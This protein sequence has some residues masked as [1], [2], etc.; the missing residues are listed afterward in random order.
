MKLNKTYLAVILALFSYSALAGNAVVSQSTQATK[1]AINSVNIGKKGKTQAGTI[2][3]ELTKDGM[4]KTQIATETLAD[5]HE[6]AKQL[7]QVKKDYTVG[8]GLSQ[9]MSCKAVVETKKITTSERM[10]KAVA[11]AKQDEIISS[12]KAQTPA[13]K[14][15]ERH[16]THKS[17]YCG[18]AE[19]KNGECLQSPILKPLMDTD[20]TNLVGQKTM[21]DE[22]EMGALAYVRNLVD[23]SQTVPVDCKTLACDDLRKKEDTFHSISNAVQGAFLEIIVS[24]MNV[25]DP[26]RTLAVVKLDQ[27]PEDLS[28]DNWKAEDGTAYPADGV[29]VVRG[30]DGKA[31]GIITPESGANANT[32][33]VEAGLSYVK[34]NVFVVGDS[35]A[36]G[37]GQHLGL[38]KSQNYAQDG[39]DPKF[40]LENFVSKLVKEHPN[41]KGKIVYLS[42]GYSNNPS[43]INLAQQQ[44]DLLKKAG[45]GVMLLGVANDYLG[46]EDGTPA[47]MNA[48]LEELARKNGISFAGGFDSKEHK[49]GLGKNMWLHPQGGYYDGVTKRQV[50]GF[51]E[52]AKETD[53][54]KTPTL[55]K[56]IYYVGDDLISNMQS[57]ASQGGNN[58]FMAKKG[59][60]PKDF[61]KQWQKFEEKISKHALELAKQKDKSAKQG[62]AKHKEALAGLAKGV[63]VVLST[64]TMNDKNHQ[65]F[66]YISDTLEKARVFK[67]TYGGDFIVM[68]IA[69][70]WDKDIGKASQ[71]ND[72][73]QKQAETNSLTF[74]GGYNSTDGKLPKYKNTLKI[75]GLAFAK[76]GYEV[77]DASG[78][79][80]R[81]R[82]LKAG[83]A[84]MKGEK[85]VEIQ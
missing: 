26:I 81:E 13:Q 31:T 38:A 40:I 35:I 56:T 64:G 33:T 27:K 83:Y 79:L 11:R 59:A 21:S 28:G 82:T 4:K 45:A 72:W 49:A 42:T 61:A 39:K 65:E 23:N 71:R 48:H 67:Q 60:S 1:D 22:E 76:I 34:E 37:M 58:I 15:A 24:R 44:I 68:G 47:K 46:K 6:L 9:S 19:V 7:N 80:D 51:T 3:T 29:N 66:Q 14:L 50:K 18:V 5:Q 62:D 17:L 36:N 20:F 41:L 85:D 74:S 69:K 12:S 16:Q 52:V 55:A 43:R 78:Q 10:T 54:L 57:F 75:L 70:S 2:Y 53:S 25:G 73:L 77:G 8:R 63:V 84:V 30:G 32:E